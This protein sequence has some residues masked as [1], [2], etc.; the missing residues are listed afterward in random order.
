MARNRYIRTNSNYVLKEIHQTTNIGNIY[1]RNWM[2]ISDLNSYAPGSLPAYGLNGFKMAITTSGTGFK[3]KHQYG[4]WLKNE[5]SLYWSINTIEDENTTITNPSTQLVLKPSFTSITDFAYFGSASKLIENAILNI[6]KNFPAEIYLREDYIILDGAMVYFVDNP[7]NIEFDTIFYDETDVTINPLRIFSKSYKDY[8][9]YRKDGAN[10]YMSWER[11]ILNNDPCNENG[12]L[13][14]II[15]LGTPIDDTPVSLFYYNYNGVKTLFHDGS[16]KGG[17]IRPNRKVINSFF[18][19]LNDFESNLLNKKKNYTISI[20][21]PEED[22]DGWY[23]TK[24]ET[25]TWP[26]AEYGE[27]NIDAFSSVFEEYA[28]SLSNIGE[29]YDKYHTN[30]LWSHMTHEAIVNFDNTLQKLGGDYEDNGYYQSSE[31]M[32]SFIYVMGRNFDVLKGYIDGISYSNKVSYDESRNNPDCFLSDS[33]LNGG[34]DIKTPV[35]AAYNKYMTGALYL[36]HIDGYTVQDANYE[37]YRRLLLN[38]NAIMLAKGTKRSIEMVMSLFGYYS[39]NFVEHSFHD[40]VRDGKNTLV[41]WADLND[42]EKKEILRNVYEITEYVYVTDEDSLAYKDGAVSVVKEIN[43][44]KMSYDSESKDNYQGLPVK[45]VITIKEEPYIVKDSYGN[46]LNLG[47]KTVDKNY[48]IPW[49][50][51]N[52]E[53]D[54]QTYFESKGGWGLTM[55]KTNNVLDYGEKYYETNESLKIYDETIKY[56]NFTDNIYDLNRMVGKSPKTNTIYYVYDI[57]DTDKYDWGLLPGESQQ[58]PTMSHY[59]ILKD[60][61]NSDVL[62]VLR[63]ENGNVMIEN[64]GVIETTFYISDKDGVQISLGEGNGVLVGKEIIGDINIEE[65][66]QN[67]DA[68]NIEWLN[69]PT[70]KYGWKNI[71]EE[72]LR[73]NITIDSQ[74][75]FY[76]EGITE[77][78]LG[79]NPHCGFGTYD[80]GETFKTS[81]EK[82]FKAAYE[83]DEYYDVDELSDILKSNLNDDSHKDFSFEDKWFILNKSVDNIKT[84]FFTDLTQEQNIYQLNTIDSNNYSIKNQ[85]IPM[86]G[87]TTI[88]VRDYLDREQLDENIINS[89]SYGDKIFNSTQYPIMIP[90]NMEDI[91]NGEVEDE[92]AANSIVNSKSLYIE[93]LPDY[94]S[95]Q[96]MYEFIDDIVMYYAKQVIPSTTLL[97]YKVPMTGWG[98]FCYSKTYLQAALI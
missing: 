58:Q 64:E 5:D 69:L 28:T 51:R 3:K 31:R 81:F 83:D 34:W 2:T 89:L 65:Y 13:L 95:P 27:W 52:K 93:F 35:P 96:S 63:D 86:V 59:F 30:N 16:Y 29:F 47:Y 79:N 90:V 85:E 18:K 14:S 23:I 10:G 26:K 33:L 12:S 41:K 68:A 73:A 32:K 77:N 71:S 66:L 82:L 19:N 53:Y 50:D 70:K 8:L 60:E 91:E 56:L 87:D 21:T 40:V 92:A 17:Y 9:F 4:S 37:F 25:Y 43:S 75:I 98:T 45:E 76:L 67:G 44:L 88:S 1:E 48:L 94:K 55:S 97:K 57:S 78:N 74:R 39:L 6:I 38:S 54:S 15:S 46:D 80:D 22:E 7:F 11:M 24:R 62:G 72:E 49:F 20:D 61:N 84:W 42:D 36:G